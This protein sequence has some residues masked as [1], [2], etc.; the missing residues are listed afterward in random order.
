VIGLTS[1]DL[2]V[3]VGIVLRAA[4]T[5]LPIAAADR[6]RILAV[7]ILAAE[8]LLSDIDDRPAG[9]ISEDSRRALALVPDAEEWAMGFTRQIRPTPKG[10]QRHAAPNTVRHAVV[11]I[12]QACV[13]DPDTA[14]RDLLAATIADVEAWTRHDAPD[15]TVF[16]TPEWEAAC[17][18][19]GAVPDRRQ[20]ATP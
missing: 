2:H 11:G 18:L 12:A 19:T 1:D 15:S 13:R 3:D 16:A 17:Q 5:A 20:V 4:T 9:S 8:R 7:S 14:L 10:F 6:Q